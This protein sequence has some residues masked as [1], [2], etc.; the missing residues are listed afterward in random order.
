MKPRHLTWLVTAAALSAGLSARAQQPSTTET[1][2]AGQTRGTQGSGATGAGDT[3]ATPGNP[4]GDPATDATTR[5]ADESR[6]MGTSPE[7]RTRTAD[8]MGR[9]YDRAGSADQPKK[10]KRSFWDRITGRNK[11]LDAEDRDGMPAET[12]SGTETRPQP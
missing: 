12:G 5:P 7:D 4:A 11:H 10:K 2:P 8:D 3:G 9:P 6:P 1:D